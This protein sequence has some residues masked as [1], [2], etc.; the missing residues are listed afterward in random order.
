[1]HHS[2]NVWQIYETLI[3]DAEYLDLVM[4]MYNLIEYSSNYSET[5]RSSW[6]ISKMKQLILRLMLLMM[7]NLNLLNIMLNY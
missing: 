5:T 4:P 2:L 1:M 7:I 6:F 3:D